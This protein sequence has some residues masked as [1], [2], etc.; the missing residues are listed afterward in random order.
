MAAR[1]D[2]PEPI[3]RHRRV[4][5]GGQLDV[6]RDLLL[7]LREAGAP[8]NAVDGLV[9][10]GGDQPGRRIRGAAGGWPLLDGDGVR[11]LQRLLR[12]VE[13]SEQADE[14]GEDAAVVGAKRFFDADGC[15]GSTGYP[16]EQARASRSTAAARSS[17]AAPR[18]SARPAA[19]DG[20]GRWR[21]PRRGPSRPRR[22]SRRAAPSSP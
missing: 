4:L 1:E 10:R 19:A 16:T 21:G 20:G 12:H 11:L 22:C 14:G 9:T 17:S 18:W 3:L 6:P 8:A 2:E 7:H 13:I 5:L 15:S